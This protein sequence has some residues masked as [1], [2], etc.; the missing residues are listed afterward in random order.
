VKKITFAILIAAAATLAAPANGSAL[1][2][3]EAAV[4]QQVEKGTGPFAD[5]LRECMKRIKT[6]QK[7]RSCSIRPAPQDTTL[8]NLVPASYHP[9]L[10]TI[11]KDMRWGPAVNWNTPVR[12]GQI[13]ALS[14]R[15]VT[16]NNR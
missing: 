6:G 16:S 8:G 12:K 11:Q 5:G 2:E 14:L 10:A 9:Y 1:A 4:E 7:E 3:F 15:V 13:V